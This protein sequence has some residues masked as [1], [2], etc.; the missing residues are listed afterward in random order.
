VNQDEASRVFAITAWWETLPV[1]RRN[2]V[3]R[4]V[5]LVVENLV[6]SRLL[7]NFTRLK[8]VALIRSH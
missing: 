8:I 3:R 2:F 4:P 1:D 7:A 6:D 5:S